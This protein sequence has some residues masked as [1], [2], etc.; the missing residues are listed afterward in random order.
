[1]GAY[2]SLREAG[3][4]QE[5]LHTGHEPSIWTNVPFTPLGRTQKMLL[6]RPGEVEFAFPAGISQG[7]DVIEVSEA[8]DLSVL[9]GFDEAA[10]HLFSGLLLTALSEEQP[11]RYRRGLAEV[12]LKLGGSQ[13][14]SAS[15]GD[16]GLQS[17]LS[18]IKMDK[19]S[20]QESSAS[21]AGGGAPWSHML[22]Y[23]VKEGVLVF[24]ANDVESCEQTIRDIA[25]SFAEPPAAAK[26]ATDQ[27]AAQAAAES[28][29]KTVLHP[30]GTLA[31]PVNKNLA[32]LIAAD[33]KRGFVMHSDPEDQADFTNCACF[34]VR[35][36]RGMKLQLRGYELRWACEQRADLGPVAAEAA[37]A[38][39]EQL[40]RQVRV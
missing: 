35:I 32:Q 31:A 28:R 16:G 1:M 34:C 24:F 12:N 19:L 40:W 30:V 8:S 21:A 7:E 23:S 22:L 2:F 26:D 25:G 3:Q 39:W 27:A 20:T 10:G 14:A 33:L 4:W 18:T 29:I 5:M 6:H 15:F 37:S 36:L 13:S 11:H 9:V 17:A 38:V